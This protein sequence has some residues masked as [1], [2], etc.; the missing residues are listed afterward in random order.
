MRHVQ[1]CGEAYKPQKR[2]SNISKQDISSLLSFFVGPFYPLGSG[3][4]RPGFGS[5]TLKTALLYG[6]HLDFISPTGVEKGL[7]SLKL[8]SGFLL[9]GTLLLLNFM[10][11]S[12]T[13]ILHLEK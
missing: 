7:T 1:A 13:G 5:T 2:T 10:Q 11:T 12:G 3:S 4:R 6:I 8:L 9:L